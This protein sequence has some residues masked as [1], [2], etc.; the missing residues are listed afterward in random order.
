MS[1]VRQVQEQVVNGALASHES[2]RSETHNGHHSNATILDLLHL[3]L[4][5]LLRGGG[6]G[7]RVEPPTTGISNFRSGY[8]ELG[9]DRILVYATRVLHILPAAHLNPVHQDHLH[10]EEGQARTNSAVRHLTRL[11]PEGEGT[12]TSHGG[13]LGKEDTRYTQHGPTAVHKLGL[14]EPLQVLGIRSQVQGVEPE[15]TRQ[16][17][18]EVSRGILA[19]KPHRA[20]RSCHGDRGTGNRCALGRISKLLALYSGTGS[21]RYASDGS[22]C[23][24]LADRF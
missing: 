17:S 23:R 3:V 24:S 8:R 11:G 15:V 9:E 16:R 18:V 10:P 2:L 20:G 21:E 7:E 12:R 4:C 5:H 22:H 14:L 19:G 1:R 6:H 13:S